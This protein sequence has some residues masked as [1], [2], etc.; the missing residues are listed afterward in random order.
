MKLNMS[1]AE[2]LDM[3]TDGRIPQEVRETMAGAILSVIDSDEMTKA[4]MA[5]CEK[6]VRSVMNGAIRIDTTGG[7]KTEYNLNGW[8][9]EIV[10]KDFTDKVKELDLR[11][12]IAEIAREQVNKYLESGTGDVFAKKFMEE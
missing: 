5:K 12:V 4:I 7:W 8:A 3:M 11:A 9:K 6:E 1:P 2:F 10:L